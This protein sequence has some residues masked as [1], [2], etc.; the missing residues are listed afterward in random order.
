MSILGM[1]N[2][3]ATPSNDVI[4]DAQNVWMLTDQERKITLD[5][6]CEEIID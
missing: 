2:V 1:E 5:K 3:S 4:P 6:L